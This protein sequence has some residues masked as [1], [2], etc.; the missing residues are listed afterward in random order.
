MTEQNY[1]IRIKQDA[2][3]IEVEGDKEFVEK[4]IEEFKKVLPGDC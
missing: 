1:R 2:I 3:E 4:H